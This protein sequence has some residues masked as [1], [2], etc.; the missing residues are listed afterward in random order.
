MNAPAY[1][2][3]DQ[4]IA[5]EYTAAHGMCRKCSEVTPHD[6]LAGL[7]GQCGRCFAAYCAEA[8]GN[9]PPPRT[10]SERLAVLKR[11]SGLASGTSRNEAAYTAR[12]LRDM[13][14]SGKALGPS[15]L[16]VLACC[17]AKLAGLP[18]PTRAPSQQAAAEEVNA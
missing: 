13:A 9:T 7:G 18:R 15:Q 12:R 3:R 6:V 8:N 4:R 11:L 2:S 16:W 14:A 1:R 10:R 5:D 17:E